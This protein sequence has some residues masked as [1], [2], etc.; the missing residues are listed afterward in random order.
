MDINENLVRI[1]HEL[2]GKY[3]SGAELAKR[4]KVSR[5]T[6]WNHIHYL[7]QQGYKFDAT[8]NLGYRLIS[9]PDRMLPD[10]ISFKLRTKWVGRK[11]VSYEEVDSTNNIAMK[12]ATEGAKEGTAVFAEYQRSGKGRLHRKW[13]SPKR[14]DILLS[15]ILRPDIPPRKVTQITIASAIAAVQTIRNLYGLPAMIK[16]PND[17]YIKERK[18]AGILI[19]MSAELD[20]INHIVIGIGVNV[21]SGVTDFPK[22][23][24]GSA[25]SIN[26]ELGKN[27]CRIECTRELLRQFEKQ[28]DRLYSEGFDE[29]RKEWLDLSLMLGRR[30]EVS[31]ERETVAGMPIRLDDDGA[32]ILRTDTGIIRK[33]SGGDVILD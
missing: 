8:T 13:H 17:I 7:I 30:I 25:T 22:D 5:T 20:T 2:D 23:I 16:W 18:C 33:I 32:L 4:L 15:L 14:K 27:C 24:R 10:E 11:I 9:I 6:I 31:S 28:F 29:I 19:E 26:I 1:F 3:F 21:N 12:L